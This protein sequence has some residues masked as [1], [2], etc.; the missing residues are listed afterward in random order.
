MT[1]Q[2]RQLVVNIPTGF[3]SGQHLRLA[4]QGN[5]GCGGGQNAMLHAPSDPRRKHLLAAMPD[6]AWQRWLPRLELVDLPLGQMLCESGGKMSH[7]CFPVSAIVSL[8]FVKETGASPEIAVVGNEG[9]VGISL[10]MGGES[11]PN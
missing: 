8:L 10:F 2:S 3:R 6:A 7:V 11:T 5:L 1:T 4:G 9:R